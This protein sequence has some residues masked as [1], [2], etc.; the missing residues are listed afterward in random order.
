MTDA[1][2]EGERPLFTAL[3][4]G[5]FP[6]PRCGEVLSPAQ[7]WCLNCGDPARTVIAPAPRWRLPLAILAAITALAL[8]V[9]VAAFLALSADDPPPSLT[10][11]QTITTQPGSPPIPGVETPLIPPAAIPPTGSTT[12]STQKTST[13]PTV[14]P[15]TGATGTGGAAAPQGTTK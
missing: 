7:D 6:C 2:Q 9:L 1:P 12:P 13:T 10:T 11:T 14:Q 5:S 4:P 3:P 8:G 15:T